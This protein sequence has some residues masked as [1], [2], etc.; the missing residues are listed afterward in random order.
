MANKKHVRSS[1]PLTRART[2]PSST[3]ADLHCLS[4]AGMT[5]DQLAELSHIFMG[6]IALERF[7]APYHA[8]EEQASVPPSRAELVSLL[9]SINER[10][11][12]QIEMLMDK[13]TVLQA[14]MLVDNAAPPAAP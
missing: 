7:I 5:H 9:R 4:L 3:K 12:R 10:M 14:Q 11:Q 1:A 13:I 8:D 2:S 6:Y